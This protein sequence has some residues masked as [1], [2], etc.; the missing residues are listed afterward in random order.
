[1]KTRTYVFRLKLGKD[2]TL[3]SE[4]MKIEFVEVMRPINFRQRT[5]SLEEVDS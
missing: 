3:D 1:M 5:Y 2:P 4:T